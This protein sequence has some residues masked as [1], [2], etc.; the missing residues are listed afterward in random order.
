MGY[1]AEHAEVNPMKRMKSRHE[2]LGVV[3]LITPWNFP[4][5]T[6]LRKMIPALAA[7]NTV[8]LKPSELTPLTAVALFHLMDASGLPPGVANLVLGEGPVVGKALVQHLDVRAISFTGS[9]VTGLQL[10]RL[11]DARGVRFQA[12]MGGANTLVVL[13]DADLE[14][15]ADAA[16]SAGFA[17]CG[18]WCTGTG[19]VIV[20]QEKYAEFLPKLLTR[21]KKMVIGDGRDARVNMGPLISAQQRNKIEQAVQ[22][23]LAEGARLLC[24]GRRPADPALQKGY[25]YEP[26][27]LADVTAEMEAAWEEIFGPVLV[28]MPARDPDEALALANGT[29]YGLAFSV[30]T[31]DAEKAGKFLREVEAGLCHVNLPTGFRDPVLPLLGWKDSGRGWPEAGKYGLEFLTRTKAVY[32]E[33][34]TCSKPER[35]Q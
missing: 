8:V 21:L 19:R 3:L 6:V 27:L 14:A 2:P 1:I 30:Y 17:C 15:A 4:L 20:E 5:A 22:R 23:A 28:A 25:F 16:V 9:T 18:Q 26:T 34:A 32:G 33:P 11:L 31:R 29:R 24:G 35:S 12:E 7:G 10:A 13:A